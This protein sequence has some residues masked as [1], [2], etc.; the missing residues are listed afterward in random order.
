MLCVRMQKTRKIL[1]KLSVSS[2]KV[3]SRICQKSSM[4]L[5]QKQQNASL[6]GLSKLVTIFAKDAL[7]QITMEVDGHRKRRVYSQNMLTDSVNPGKEQRMSLMT[8]GASTR[9][10][11]PMSKTSTNL[12]VPRVQILEILGRGLSRKPFNCSIQFAL[13]QRHPKRFSK[14]ALK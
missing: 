5:G 1:L 10:R 6:I 14:R 8:L 4:E 7:T 2:A 12:Q 13:Q 3:L 9:E 11:P